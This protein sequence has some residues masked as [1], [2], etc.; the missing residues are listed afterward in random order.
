MFILVL[1]SNIDLVTCFNLHLTDLNR[2]V[3]IP[4][5][6]T[7]FQMLTRASFGLKNWDHFL[8][9]TL[10]SSDVARI[11]IGPGLDWTSLPV[12]GGVGGMEYSQECFFGGGGGPGVHPGEVWIWYHKISILKY[13]RAKGNSEW[14]PPRWLRPWCKDLP[15]LTKRPH[16]HKNYLIVSR[17]QV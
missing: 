7:F 1:T 5:V 12:L 15:E 16:T 2:S 4:E 6:N 17:W 10:L 9:D 3:F 13:S 8:V 11:L 14:P